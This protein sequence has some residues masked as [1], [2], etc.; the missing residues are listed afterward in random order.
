MVQEEGGQ[1]HVEGDITKAVVL[2]WLVE[3]PV[4]NAVTFALSSLLTD[5]SS[6]TAVMKID[7]VMKPFRLKPVPL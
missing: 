1:F 6:M 5:R 2:R 3:D 7:R 4:D